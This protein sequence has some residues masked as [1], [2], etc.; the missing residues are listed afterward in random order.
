MT[1]LENFASFPIFFNFYYYNQIRHQS[2]TETA[3]PETC[4]VDISVPSQDLG[5]FACLGDFRFGQPIMC[6]C[7]AGLTGSFRAMVSWYGLYRRYD[8][9]NGGNQQQP[10]TLLTASLIPVTLAGQMDQHQINSIRLACRIQSLNAQLP[11]TLTLTTKFATTRGLP[12]ATPP[13]PSATAG[14]NDGASTCLLYEGDSNGSINQYRDDYLYTA[15]TSYF[16]GEKDNDGIAAMFQCN[17]DAEYA[18]G[19][20]GAQIKTAIGHI[21]SKYKGKHQGG[22]GDAQFI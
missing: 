10:N 1:E 11:G 14:N 16:S 2:L 9:I 13:M 21:L 6:S 17:S 12:R 7:R 4:A 22:D 15:Y 8:S 5:F 3:R 18:I 19:M 20:T